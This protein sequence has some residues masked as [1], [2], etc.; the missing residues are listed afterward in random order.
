MGTVLRFQ[1]TRAKQRGGGTFPNLLVL[2]LLKIANCIDG[3]LCCKGCS[4]D[5][6]WSCCLPG[7]PSRVPG[8]PVG[9]HQRPCW[10]DTVSPQNLVVRMLTSLSSSSD[11]WRT[12]GVS[13]YHLDFILLVKTPRAWWSGLQFSH[14]TVCF[15]RSCFSLR[16]QHSQ[17]P[18]MWC[19]VSKMRTHK[20][21]ALAR[22]ILLVCILISFYSLRL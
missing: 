1:L 20:H 15:F 6:C 19:H 16:L 2:F 17:I 18:P 22:F 11:P 4:A 14:L 7:Y 12:P 5:L 8:H 13:V 9:C 21:C 10:G 3:Y